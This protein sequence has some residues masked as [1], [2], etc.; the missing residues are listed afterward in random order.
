MYMLSTVV[1]KIIQKFTLR[2]VQI[3]GSDGKI[4]QDQ[5]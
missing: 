3:C 5:N 4:E 1:T 2:S